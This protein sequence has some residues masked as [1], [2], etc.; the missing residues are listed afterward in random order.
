MRFRKPMIAASCL[1]LSISALL[2]ARLQDKKSSS[3]K[4]AEAATA[5]LATLDAEQ[6][7]RATFGFN[8]EERLNWHFIPRERKGLPIKDLEG[9]A[10]KAAHRLLASGLSAAG[11]D[12]TLSIM[13]LEEL[14]YLLEQGDRQTRRD[15]R[16]PQKYYF[17]IFGTP[18][19]TG[20]WGW[21]V[22][23]HHVSLNYTIKNGKLVS[24]TPEFFG[25]NPGTI[26]AGPERQI[27]VLGPEEDIARQ[28]LKLCSPENQKIM[29]IEDKAPQD[30]RG[31][32]VAQVETTAPV[33]L[34]FSKMSS[35][36]KKLVHE[37]LN[38]YLKNMPSDVE[39]ERRA[40]INTGGMDAVYFAWWGQADLNQPH[41]YRLQGPS[42]L[43]EY[44]NVQNTAN[45]V[46]SYWRNMA[47]DFD[48]PVNK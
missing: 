9:P 40:R 14:L 22:E 6:K 3:N 15:K 31:G 5:F 21:R 19:T 29:W 20:M 37:L 47:G 13:S 35:D 39:K 8:D 12:Q 23:G 36:Q 30:L 7:A 24:T 38:E 41:Y 32:G 10:L 16:D 33:G 45:H 2:T 43:V 34:S 26:D 44:N 42:F 11:Y 46:H 27:R 25:A 4:M 18:A 1:V 28:I 17:S 48:V